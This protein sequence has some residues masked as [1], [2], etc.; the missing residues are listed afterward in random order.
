MAQY[1][2]WTTPSRRRRIIY[3]TAKK[4]TKNVIECGTQS[5]ITHKRNMECVCVIEKCCL[6][7][8]F[9]KRLNARSVVRRENAALQLQGIFRKMR[10]RVLLRIARE[11]RCRMKEMDYASTVICASVRRKLVEMMLSSVKKE[12]LKRDR[13][14]SKAA[15]YIQRLLRV[16]IARWKVGKLRDDKQHQTDAVIVIQGFCRGIM[17]KTLM[18]TLRAR[19]LMAAIIQRHIRGVITRRRCK[20]Y[21]P[22]AILIQRW[23]RMKKKMCITPKKQE[24]ISGEGNLSIPKLFGSPLQKVVVTADAN[25]M[26]QY[27]DIAQSDLV[28]IETNGVTNAENKTTCDRM[29]KK[30]GHYRQQVKFENWN[31]SKDI[32]QAA[33]ILQKVFFSYLLRKQLVA[34]AATVITKA[35]RTTF[36]RLKRWRFLYERQRAA[37]YIQTLVRMYLAKLKTCAFRQKRLESLEQILQKEYSNVQWIGDF[38]YLEWPRISSDAGSFCKLKHSDG[39]TCRK[40]DYDYSFHDEWIKMLPESAQP[41]QGCYLSEGNLSCEGA[42]IPRLNIDF[43]L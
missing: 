22:S 11:N 12:K 23:W 42:T 1:T 25:V 33:K 15:M 35:A 37:A 14:E 43:S 38:Q 41:P 21:L 3:E 39:N 13:D 27:H 20:L 31:D 40:G 28:T 2:S 16:S 34:T 7:Y 10:A 32:E 24:T 26:P 8:L 18:R 36:A 30:M 29:G 9:Q 19:V 4:W 17:A 6:R 5:A